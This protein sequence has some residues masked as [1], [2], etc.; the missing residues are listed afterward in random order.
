MLDQFARAM[1]E[2][3]GWDESAA[4]WVGEQAAPPTYVINLD[5]CYYCY[6]SPSGSTVKGKGVPVTAVSHSATVTS[7]ETTG[8]TCGSLTSSCGKW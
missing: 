8:S 7:R 5:T 6:E 2:A 3:K 1:T 4:R